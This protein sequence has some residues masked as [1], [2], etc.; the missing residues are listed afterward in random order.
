MHRNLSFYMEYV[1]ILKKQIFEINNI[2]KIGGTCVMLS[3]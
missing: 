2:Q 3:F 1:K